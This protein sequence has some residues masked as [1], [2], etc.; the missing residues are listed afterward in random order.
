MGLLS[1]LKKTITG[2]WADVSLSASPAQRGETITFTVDVAVQ[3][4]PIE[5]DKVY[6]K[7]RCREAIDIPRYYSAQLDDRSYIHV[8]KHHDFFTQELTL[9]MAQK[10]AANQ[11][12]SF[13]GS[14]EIPSN[15][16]PSM[17]GKYSR[18]E[19]EALAGLDMKGNDPDSGWVTLVV[20]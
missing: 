3:S 12:Y 13:S 17:T 2:S 16:P 9:G 7:L 18:T 11:S 10:M 19:W 15:L 14:A 8:E 20:R 4:D 5:I 1:K 6:I